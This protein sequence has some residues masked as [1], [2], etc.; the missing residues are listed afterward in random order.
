[1]ID[2]KTVEDFIRFAKK[3]IGIKNLVKI[4]LIPKREGGITT[5]GYFPNKEIVIRVSGRHLV[6]VLRSIAHEL[7]H[8]KQMEDERIKGD[9]PDIGGP[10][11]DEANAVAGQL[12]K[13][14][15]KAGNEHI[16]ESVKKDLRKLIR[17]EV[18][19]LIFHDLPND[20]NK[21]I[22]GRQKELELSNASLEQVEAEAK[23][24]SKEEGVS[25]HVNEIS[26]G[27]YKVENF[28]DSDK[29]V[30]SFENGIKK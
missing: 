26:P 17:E 6:D 9:E 1:M 10:I 4:K 19:S 16:Y 13:K 30:S 20:L 24:I 14:F 5:A 27:V 8:H 21:E 25:Q 15:A 3:E 23:Q 12:I 18:R 11:E 29:T 7:V 28:F 22:S 2:R